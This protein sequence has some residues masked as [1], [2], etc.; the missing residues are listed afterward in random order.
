MEEK[1]KIVA[2]D[3]TGFHN[4]KFRVECIL[5]TFNLL[6]CLQREVAEVEELRETQEDLAATR[7]EKKKKVAERIMAEKKCKSLLVQAIADNQLELIKDCATPKAIW[8]TLKNVFERRGVA[9]QLIIRKQL[10]TLKYSDRGG[11][12]LAEHLLRFD[13]LIRELK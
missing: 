2:F 4:W 9:G 5:D 13:R 1:A 8:T 3:G 6:D 11:A 12:S 10:L 7:A